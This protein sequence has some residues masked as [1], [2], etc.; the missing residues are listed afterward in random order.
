MPKDTFYLTT[1]IDYANSVPHIGHAF[2]KIGADVQA[3]WRRMRGDGVYFLMGNDEHSLNVERKAKEQGV[4]PKAYCDDMAG[5]FRAVWDK[6]SIRNDRFIQTTDA[7][8][9][10]ACQEL[11]RLIRQRSPD[12]LYRGKYKGWYCVSCEAYKKE[13][14]LVE[15]KCPN[16]RTQA[17]QW[18]EE[19]NVFFRLSAYQARIE[20]LVAEAKEFVVEPESR[21][22]EI[23]NVIRGGL[24]DISISRG[25]TTW[26]VPLPDE[27]GH[28]MYVWFDALIN[29]L[30]GAGFPDDPASFARRWPADVHVIGK[31]ITRFHC[32]IWPAM[33]TAAGLPLPRRVF[34]H[35]FV[36]ITQDGERVK[37]S[38]SM[39]I[40]ADPGEIADKYGADALRHF[41]M[42]ECPFGG[43]GDFAWD[44]F[45]ARYNADLANDLGNL[46]HR[47][48]NMT[49]RYLSGKVRR[50]IKEPESAFY[51]DAHGFCNFLHGDLF[52]RMMND[53][54]FNEALA[55]AWECVTFANQ[56][57]EKSAPWTSAKQKE[58]DQVARD[59][60]IV[61][62]ALRKIALAVYPFLPN[63]AE[64]LWKRLGLADAGMPMTW[65]GQEGF[66]V[67]PDG[68]AVT[69]G[70][71]LFPRID[72]KAMT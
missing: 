50:L 57:I 37:L 49:S 72:L 53:F 71:P 24:D 17:P 56:F 66:G 63:A 21:R 54:Q 45:Y 16:H 2:E 29:Y 28:V 43:D 13:S 47:Y 32:V 67:T 10:R 60:Y 69:Q 27:P 6:L 35:G 11:Y 8:H 38:K 5:K 44:K 70:E 55:H 65:T 4:D 41:L 61:G 68:T 26:G 23:L 12:D 18:I 20:K 3:R 62:E 15:G 25:G 48:T 22:N 33:L 39:G 31:D 58:L 14:D 30:T 40:S 9:A 7:D 51:E 19:E 34:A 1:A 64:R 46:L 42:R 36:Y 52:I 59:L